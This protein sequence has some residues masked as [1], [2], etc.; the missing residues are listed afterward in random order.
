MSVGKICLLVKY[1]IN[2]KRKNDGVKE[3]Q[4]HNNHQVIHL[5]DE[6]YIRVFVI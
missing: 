4:S 1:F 5:W 3:K 2:M 6:F